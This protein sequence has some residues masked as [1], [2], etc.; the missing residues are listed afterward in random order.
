MSQ[1]RQP[2]GTPSGGQFTASARNEASTPLGVGTI[3]KTTDDGYSRITRR[4]D[5]AGRMQ[6]GPNGEPALT[7]SRVDDTWIRTMHYRD[8]KRQDP[9]SG[10]P[11]GV[12]Y[13][14]DGTIIETMRLSDDQLND[15]PNGEPAVVHYHFSGNVSVEMRFTDDEANDGPNGE[16]AVVHYDESGNVTQTDHYRA[17]NYIG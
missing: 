5:D 15:G 12:R 2:K 4:Y 10:E 7:V 1:P 11:A 8:G 3:V 17:G 16:P 14:H 13:E 6:D 9:P